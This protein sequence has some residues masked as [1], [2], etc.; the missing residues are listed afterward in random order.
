MRFTVNP[1][2]G[3]Y[4][5]DFSLEGRRKR[6]YPGT[7]DKGTALL[8]ARQMSLD[9]D[10]G[11]FDL[12]LGKYRLS[13]KAQ[14]GKKDAPTKPSAPRK[15]LELWDAW[16][17]SLELP[18]QTKNDHYHCI[19]QMILKYQPE[20]SDT[21]WFLKLKESYSA[22]T[23]N[24]RRTFL[25]SC[26]DWAK[27]E[28]LWEDKNPYAAIKPKKK[29]SSELL[30]P[31]TKEEISRIIRAF[32]TNQFCP[33]ASAYKHS[34]YVP[35]LKWQFITG[36]RPGE[37]IALQWKHVNFASRKI[38]ITQALGRDFELAPYASRKKLK[39][40]K[41]GE[42][43]FIPMNDA[44]YEL[45]SS[46]ERGKPDDWVFPGQRGNYMDIDAFRDVWAKVLAG[47]GIPYRKPYFS[48][49]TV[50]SEVASSQGLLAA[51]K[52]ARHKSCDMVSRHYA[53]F[54]GELQLP[55]LV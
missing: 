12:S 8:L 1:D 32:E 39:A 55:N 15:L 9:W 31:F 13:Q 30:Q 23:F 51:A 21:D 19:R 3:S 37:S 46:L 4:R 43:G 2:K 20:C 22:Y 53:A 33:E 10:M 26:F 48:R 6:F 34:H 49:H 47:L 29:A 35:F 11:Q 18:E 54:T 41:T 5:I 28:G 45:L 24:S 25:K 50:L 14:Q 44:L 36:C 16:V 42:S 38:F 40:T 17:E 27:Q 52:L 7:K